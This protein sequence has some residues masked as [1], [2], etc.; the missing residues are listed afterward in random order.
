V[1]TLWVTWVG[2]YTNTSFQ[3]MGTATN[4]FVHCWMYFYYF[5]STFGSAYIRY[6]AQCKT[7]PHCTRANTPTVLLL[8]LL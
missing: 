3:W 6:T 2:I 4:T 7:N 1:L 5:V 8:L